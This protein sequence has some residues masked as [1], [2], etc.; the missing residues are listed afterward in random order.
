MADFVEIGK[1]IGELVEQKNRAYGDSFRKCGE[2]LKLLYP[3][4]IQPE[5]YQDALALVRIFDKQMRIA[6]NKTAMAENPYQDIAGY[7]FLGVAN[8]EK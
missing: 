2:F 3:N 5:Q 6:T 8:N 1:R 4:G 7:G